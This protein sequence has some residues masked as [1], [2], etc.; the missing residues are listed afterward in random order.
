M[1]SSSTYARLRSWV[2]PSTF[3]NCKGVPSPRVALLL[4]NRSISTVDGGNDKTT[5]K[6]PESIRIKISDFVKELEEETASLGKKIEPPATKK[7]KTSAKSTIASEASAEGEDGSG[8]K[9]KEKERKPWNNNPN[10]LRLP[11]RRPYPVR[12]PGPMPER[13]L[14]EIVYATGEL[15]IS[16]RKLNL[17]A[18]LIRGLTVKDALLQL[19]YSQKRI[20]KPVLQAVNEAVDKAKKMIKLDRDDLVVGQAYVGGRI[21]G[22]KPDIQGRGRT[23]TIIKR[24]SKLKLHLYEHPNLVPGF[25]S[26]SLAHLQHMSRSQLRKVNEASA[27]KGGQ[28]QHTSTSSAPAAV[29]ASSGG[30]R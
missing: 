3:F 10:S 20:S 17:V 12:G 27:A 11:G 4:A 13:R 7:K 22:K 30:S 23:G 18:E 15:S 28:Q 1:I 16:P 19:Q 8:E 2:S 9:R 29:T 24:V 14:K 26:K 21:L 6:A 5:K 25:A